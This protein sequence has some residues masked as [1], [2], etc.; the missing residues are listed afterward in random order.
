M[1]K[2]TEGRYCISEK[3]TRYA[4]ALIKKELEKHNM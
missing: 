4:Y 3:D 1:Q 2:D